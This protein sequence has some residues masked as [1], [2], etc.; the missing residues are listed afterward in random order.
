RDGVELLRTWDGR[1]DSESPA[2]CVFEL[3]LAE[4]CVRAAKAKAPKEWR[5][6]VGEYGP[7]GAGHNLF[8][9]RR[10]GHLV[11]LVRTQPEGWFASCPAELESALGEV[12]RFLRRTAGPGAAFWAWGHVRR[13]RLEHPLLG[14]HRRLGPAFNLGPVPCG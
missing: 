2:A 6:V 14:K 8:T 4:M 11:G 9:D 1:L 3:F 12:V 5:T 7:G 13:L 10:V